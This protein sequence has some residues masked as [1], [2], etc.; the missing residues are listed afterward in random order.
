MARQRYD[1]KFR[2][3][4]I[5]SLEANGY[6]HRKGAL[7][8]TAKALGVPAPTLHRWFNS[9]SNPPASE[10]VSEKRKT[11]LEWLDELIPG[12]LSDLNEKRQ[13]ASFRDTGTVAAILIDKRELLRGNVTER[14]ELVDRNQ[15][16]ARELNRILNAARTRRD[17]SA[18]IQPGVGDRT[19]LQ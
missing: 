7:A 13:E 12:L 8:K 6:P 10:V 16:R 15:E 19:E 5:L 4:A 1:E 18:P 11:A 3:G 14:V 9:S 17:G 2:A